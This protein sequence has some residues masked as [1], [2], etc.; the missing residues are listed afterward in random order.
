MDK[1]TFCGAVLLICTVMG[2]ARAAWDFLRDILSWR[3]ARKAGDMKPFKL[4]HPVVIAILIVGCLVLGLT[5]IWLVLRHQ[6]KAP[7][8]ISTPPPTTAPASPQSPKANPTQRPVT[9]VISAPI[10][11]E[12]SSQPAPP[13][14]QPIQAPPAT[15]QQPSPTYQQSC[16]GGACAQG[17]GAQATYNGNIP[18]PRREMLISNM[19]IASNILSTA[20]KGSRVSITRVGQSDEIN[21]FASEVDELFFHSNFVWIVD[22]PNNVGELHLFNENGVSH[23]EGFHCSV[24]NSK[25]G[26]GLIAIQALAKAGYPCVRDSDTPTD[27]SDP[28]PVDIYLTIGTRI[29]PPD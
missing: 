5:G 12:K 2:G 19:L 25:S 7:I 26:A 16:V 22:P 9:R 15:Q 8:V 11:Q 6:P 14:A 29:I 27:H 3:R 28:H 23:G 21:K 17:P 1:S 20:P 4:T 18:P 10:Q 13:I 24:S